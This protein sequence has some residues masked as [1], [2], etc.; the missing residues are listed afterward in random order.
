MKLIREETWETQSEILEEA[1]K[2]SFFLTSPYGIQV[3]LENRNKRIY[4]GITMGKEVAR[5][6]NSDVKNGTAY[7]ELGHPANAKINEERIS[8]RFV[9]IKQESKNYFSIKA[10]IHDTP[11][12]KIVKALIEDGEGKMGIST[13]AVGSVNEK[14]GVQI[15]Q[16][17]LMLVTAGDIVA[18]PS[19][20]KAFVQGIYEGVEYD[21]IDGVLVETVCRDIEKEYKITMS[22]EEK[23]K[24]LINQFDK[25]M[26]WMAKN[27]PK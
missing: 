6:L 2:K 19:A 4:P 22:T 20:Q 21:F 14:N 25:I 9:D 27:A 8:H 23:T 26:N 15:V 13:R 18:N 17:D 24:T 7:G 12:G 16:E 11:M 10:K 1:G 3:D 5:Y